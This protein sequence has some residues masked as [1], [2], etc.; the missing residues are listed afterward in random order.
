MSRTLLGLLIFIFLG[1]AATLFFEQDN[2]YVLMR[3]GDI[4]VESSLVFFVVALLAGVWVLSIL[5]RTLK[6]TVGL[7]RWLPALYQEH[8][9]R[10]LQKALLRGLIL[11][12]EGRWPDAEKA[13]AKPSKN[14]DLQLVNYLNA[15]VAAQRQNAV[16]R[17]D[18]YLQQAADDERELLPLAVMLTRAELQAQAGQDSQALATLELLREK[19]PDHLPALQQL[20]ELSAQ[21]ED[22]A[23]VREL[24]PDAERLNLLSEQ[25]RTELGEKAWLNYLDNA[26]S[27]NLEALDKAW[28]TLPKRLRQR[29]ALRVCYVR[30]LIQNTAGHPEALRIITSTLK[31]QWVP[32]IALLYSQIEFDDS[33]AQM[34]AVED[35]IKQHG[36]QPELQLLAGQLCLKNKLWGRARSYLE[37]VLARQPDARAWLALG[38]LKEQTNDLQGAADAY[39]KGLE[40]SLQANNK[41]A[42]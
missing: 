42:V 15:A 33:T 31:H 34:A 12:R 10:S 23:R 29:P 21:V 37:S 9:E 19:Q 7:P 11:L 14:D 4:V 17:R 30:H 41:A 26:D 5:W 36:E 35:W 22:W 16:E 1:V 3:Y 28:Q 20:F 8:R 24:W 39:A 38:Q 6:L 2:G 32:D 25:R 18:Y 40:L 27:S 13:L